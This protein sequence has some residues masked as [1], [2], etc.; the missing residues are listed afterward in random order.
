MYKYCKVVNS[1]IYFFNFCLKNCI[2]ICNININNMD[3][4]LILT[5]S[6]TFL[7]LLFFLN[8]DLKFPKNSQKKIID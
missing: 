4:I 1:R 5:K 6:L 8:K 3:V 7:V 2:C